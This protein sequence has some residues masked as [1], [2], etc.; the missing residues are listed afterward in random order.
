MT[1][2]L[3]DDENDVVSVASEAS[4]SDEDSTFE[5]DN[6]DIESETFKLHSR[7][8]NPPHLPLVQ[9]FTILT[10]MI[11]HRLYLR[12]SLSVD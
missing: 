3:S 10:L 1:N 5:F 12:V 7:N 6:Y 2:D 8:N 11:L 9:L 4:S